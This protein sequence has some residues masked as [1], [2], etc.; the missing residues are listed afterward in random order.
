MPPTGTG[1][2]RLLYYGGAQAVSRLGKKQENLA[3]GHVD[4]CCTNT[5]HNTEAQGLYQLDIISLFL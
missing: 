4:D 3:D 2:V 1:T 5:E